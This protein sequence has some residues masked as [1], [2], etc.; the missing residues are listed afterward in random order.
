VSGGEPFDALAGVD[1]STAPA[2]R[3]V[4]AKVLITWTLFCIYDLN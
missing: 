1:G 4:S 2:P 3:S